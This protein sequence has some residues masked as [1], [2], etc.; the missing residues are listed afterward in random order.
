MCAPRSAVNTR[1]G[2]CEL[3][4]L[5]G[6]TP[7]KRAIMESTT[8]PDSNRENGYNPA[9]STKRKVVLGAVISGAV[10]AAVVFLVIVP[11][12]V[13]KVKED[14]SARAAQRYPKGSILLED[15]LAQSYGLESLGASQT[16]GNGTL[17]LTAT[18]LHFFQFSPDKEVEIPIASIR[19]TTITKSHLGKSA[20]IDL[21]HVRFVDANGKEDSIAWV[22]RP[23]AS[24]WQAKVASLKGP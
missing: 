19:E 23:D 15:N 17:V 21:L 16:R 9:V 18:R 6:E 2:Q 22:V 20:G 11:R 3:A 1:S 14:G 10:I 13:D 4:K 7:N 24:T 8:N 5:S 12:L